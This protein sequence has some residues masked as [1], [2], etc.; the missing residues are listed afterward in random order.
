MWSSQ[1]IVCVYSV[2]SVVSHSLQPRGLCVACHAPLS[3]G[4][5]RK[6]YWSELPFPS[7]GDL[8]NPQIKPAS[9]MSPTLASGFFTTST[10]WE[11]LH[12]TPPAVIHGQRSFYSQRTD[13]Q[14]YPSKPTA[15][16]P[17]G[18]F[19]HP[20]LA[21]RQSQSQDI[22]LSSGQKLSEQGVHT[23]LRVVDGTK[24]RLYL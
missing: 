8:P 19:L 4:F 1:W 7:P 2:A 22:R 12:W 13:K 17:D 18:D 21:G 24:C 9:L 6:E 5:S 14:I 11:A 20:S 16:A 10:T 3:M 15:L 23:K